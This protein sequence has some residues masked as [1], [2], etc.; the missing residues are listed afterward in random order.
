MTAKELLL[1]LQEELEEFE[2]AIVNRTEKD[3]LDSPIIA[4]AIKITLLLKVLHASH[5][6]KK[7][8]SLGLI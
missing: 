2:L 5:E 1:G 4:S 8:K 6:Y 7:L 3:D